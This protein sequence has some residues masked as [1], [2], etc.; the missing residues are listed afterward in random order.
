M[1]GD[2]IPI[3]TDLATR[4]EVVL[5]AQS[6]GMCRHEVVGRLAAFWGWAS[7]ETEDGL[8]RGMTVASLVATNVIQTCHGVAPNEPQACFY[9]ALIDVGWLAEDP[10]GLVVSNWDRW[11]SNSAKARLGHALRQQLYR[12]KRD[13]NVATNVATKAPPK[14]RREEK[15]KEPPIVPHGDSG[16][17]TDGATQKKGFVP[18]TL[19]EVAAY[20][21]ERDNGISAQDFLDHY[22]AVGWRYGR[23]AGKPIK[24]WRAAVRT[25]EARRRADA[26]NDPTP[27]LGF[28]N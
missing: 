21:A 10:R 22:E 9:R 17:V 4:R 14:K 2:W 19:Q 18:P 23:G 28:D 27:D 24:D 13:E 26:S 12:K 3:T 6:T 16:G 8:L 7:H 5:I 1:A 15:S 20:C 25:W 11:L